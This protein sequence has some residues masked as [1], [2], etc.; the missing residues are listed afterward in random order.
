MKKLQKSVTNLFIIS[1]KPY[2]AATRGTINNWVKSAMTRAGI[3]VTLFKPHSIR[4]ASTSAASEQVPIPIILKAAG[5]S[6]EY[7]FRNFTKDQL[8]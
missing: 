3:D 4:G 8:L 5:W 1:K 7:N 2:T 6:A